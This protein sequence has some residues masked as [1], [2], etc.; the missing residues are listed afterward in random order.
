MGNITNDIIRELVK[1]A[2]ETLETIAQ[3]IGLQDDPPCLH[4]NRVD[5]STMGNEHWVCQDCG[6]EYGQ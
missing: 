3:L 2:Q 1:H 5:M 4:K 6:F